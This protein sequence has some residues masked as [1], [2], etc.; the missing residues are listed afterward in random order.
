MLDQLLAECRSFTL[1]PDPAESLED[2]LWA[3]ASHAPALLFTSSALGDPGRLATQVRNA[4]ICCLA[5]GESP[6]RPGAGYELLQ[7]DRL[8]PER[9]DAWVRATLEGQSPPAPLRSSPG[10]P[11]PQGLIGKKEK[12]AEPSPERSFAPPLQQPIRQEPLFPAVSVLRQQVVTLWGGKPGAGRSTLAVALSHLISQMGSVKVC[13][14]DLNPYNSSLGVLLGK[15]K[16]PS[17]WFHLA[18]GLRRGS[19]SLGD[20]LRW[21]QPNWAALTGPDGNEEWI[22]MLDESILAAMIDNLRT[23]FDYIILDPEARPGLIS[24]TALRLAQTV[25]VVVSS[26]VSDVYDTTRN[27]QAAVDRGFLNRSRCH[28]VC[29]KWTETAHLRAA[30][31][32]AGMELPIGAAVPMAPQV[33][34]EAAGRGIPVTQLETVESRQMQQA[35]ASVAGL[36]ASAVAGAGAGVRGTQRRGWFG[37]S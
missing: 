2:A 12:P 8:A 17:S 11:L 5:E 3:A 7:A 22:G 4:R 33:A 21:V 34:L 10:F 20:A 19:L 28:L 13:T 29:S 14:V 24:E 31:V 27:F 1:L 35:C 32:A 30:D 36:I 23:Q 9:I 16:E 18:E 15:E 6:I 37:R 25:L 26:D